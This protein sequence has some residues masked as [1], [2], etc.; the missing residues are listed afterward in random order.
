MEKKKIWNIIMRLFF[1]LA[2]GICITIFSSG[3]FVVRAA[4]SGEVTTIEEQDVAEAESTDEDGGSGILILMG[5]ML[6][7]IIA[8]VITVVATVVVTA[9]AAD[10]I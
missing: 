10:E 2:A 1:V 5:G 3:A 6:L 4:E 7:I 9:P 8:V